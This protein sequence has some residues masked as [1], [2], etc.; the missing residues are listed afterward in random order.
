MPLL[1]EL[2]QGPA[3]AETLNRTIQPLWLPYGV[4]NQY[5]SLANIIFQEPIKERS[6]PKPTTLSPVNNSLRPKT[7]VILL[8][9]AVQTPKPTTLTPRTPF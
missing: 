9:K 1:P 3:R 6:N 8:K 7:S 5:R 2:E 4:Y